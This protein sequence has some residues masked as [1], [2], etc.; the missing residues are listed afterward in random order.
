MELSSKD[1]RKILNV[2]LST[3]ADFAELYYQDKKASTYRLSHKKVDAVSK[4]SIKGVGIRLIKNRVVVYGFSSSLEVKDILKVT[5]ELAENFTG[6]QT[7]FFTIFKD[8]EHPVYE[9]KKPHDSMTLEEKLAYLKKAE[10]AMYAYSNEVVN[11]SC[12]LLEED[13]FVEIYNTD[14][15][16]ITDSRVRTR[17]IFVALASDG[18][19]FQSGSTGDGKRAG[20]EIFDE[21]DPVALGTEAAKNACELVHAPDCPS[22]EM[23]VILGNGFGGVLFHEAC[24]HP[25]EACAI[26]RNLSVF[27]GKVGQQIASPI[28]NAYDDG[29]IDDGYGSLNVDDEGNLTTRNQLI[30][31]GI[32]VNYMNDMNNSDMMNDHK[33]YFNDRDYVPTGSCRRQSYRYEPTTRMTNTFIG[34]GTSTVDEIIKATEHGLY[35]VTFT[36]GQVNPITGQFNFSAE[37]AYI[38]ENG[39]IKNLVKGACLIGYGHEILPLID[40]VGNDLKIAP[41]MCGASSGSIPV[42]VGQPTL[43]VSK[44]TVAGT[45]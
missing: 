11:A 27:K 26:S 14:G 41:G 35:C 37:R 18:K 43:R 10:D 33:E 16:H 23:P 13:E 21:L 6:E 32:L 44:M 28:V 8:V 24:G 19:S 30:K 3:G 12:N 1:I 42:T 31:D 15:K 29:T 38:I 17:V 5:K 39:E 40:M 20:L 45:K 7:K 25:L 9:V 4:N 36:G 2:G 34:N 22:G